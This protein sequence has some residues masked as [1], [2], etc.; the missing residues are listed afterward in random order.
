[1]LG[2]PLLRSLLPACAC[3]P[4]TLPLPCPA[5]TGRRG[6]QVLHTKG[7][8][9][10][11]LCLRPHRRVARLLNSA[12]FTFQVCPQSCLARMHSCPA[13]QA[14]CTLPACPLQTIGARLSVPPTSLILGSTSALPPHRPCAWQGGFDRQLHEAL[15]PLFP[16][17]L[18]PSLASGAGAAIQVRS[19]PRG[20]LGGNSGVRCAEAHLLCGACLPHESFSL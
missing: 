11:S 1:M 16:A 6:W 2:L 14:Q 17:G 7:P 12:L 15:G 20:W 10:L 4:C 13:S 5:Q 3:P 18:L 9:D 19:G 8:R